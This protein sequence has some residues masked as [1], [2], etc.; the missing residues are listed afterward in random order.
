MKAGEPAIEAD[1]LVKVLGQLHKDDAHDTEAP[2][3]RGIVV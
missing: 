3:W 2:N 1:S